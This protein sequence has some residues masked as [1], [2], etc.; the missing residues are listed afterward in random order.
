MISINNL[1]VEF[2]ARPLFHDVSFVIN[3]NDRIALTG[4]NG[5]GKSTLLKILAGLEE[6]THGTVSMPNGITVG[7]LPQ[8][9]VLADDTSV[10][11]EVKKA[12][13]ELQ[14]LKDELA[15]VQQQ[16]TERTDYESESYHE[17]LERFDYLNHRLSIE[18]ADNMEAEIE[19]TLTG[20]GFLCAS[21]LL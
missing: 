4:K 17:L 20:L 8:Q 2:S 5:A 12:F 16:M 6:P 9:M 1:E 7:Y 19:S 13:S 15:A 18:G 21:S 11:D 14:H 10:V 3:P